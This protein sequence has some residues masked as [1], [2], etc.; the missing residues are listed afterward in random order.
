MRVLYC[1]PSK[2]NSTK[3]SVVQFIYGD[4]PGQPLRQIELDNP[5]SEVLLQTITNLIG[6]EPIAA[7]VLV[8]QAASF[9]LIRV[10]ATLYNTLSYSRKLALYELSSSQL[11]TELAQ[12]MGKAKTQIDPHYS[13]APNITYAT[14]PGK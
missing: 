6:N 9:T 11:F 5:R 13:K 3:R 2:T 14:Q 12:F 10:L 4:C 1:D 8:N 7:L